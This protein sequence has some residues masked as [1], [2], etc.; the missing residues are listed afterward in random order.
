MTDNK[1][2][3]ISKKLRIFR[4]NKRLSQSVIANKIGIA[5][6]TYGLVESGKQAPT[7]YFYS[8][9]SNAFP[10]DDF[11]WLLGQ[12][13]VSE[14][15]PPYGGDTIESRLTRL[16]GKVEQILKQNEK[17]LKLLSGLI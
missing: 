3:V 13:I 7:S 12:N 9:I 11:E 16:E 8:K 5:R 10:L 15:H 17:I 6:P 14:P 1:L 4:A 2:V